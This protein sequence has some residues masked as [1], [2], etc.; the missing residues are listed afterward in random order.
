MFCRSTLRFVGAAVLA[1]A[2][3]WPGT[4]SATAIT[5]L[6]EFVITRSGITSSQLGSYEGQLVW[7]RDSF[8]DGA[9]PPSGG[10]F[11]SGVSGSYGVLGSYP[12]GSESRGLLTLNSAF[13]GPYVNANGGGRVLQRSTLLTD[14][15][16]ETQAGLKKAFHTFSVFGLFDLTI[17]SSRGDGYGISVSDGGPLGATE[18][19]DLFVRREE[20]NNVVIRLQEQDFLNS[21]INTLELD[22]LAAPLG[23]D[24]IELR[25]QRGDLATGLLTASYRFWDNGSAITDFIVMS[26]AADFFTTNG[27]ARGNFFAVQAIPEPG[28]LGIVLLAAGLLAFVRSLR[29]TR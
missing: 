12:T 1:L 14:V 6:D 20:N 16:P 9:P 17:P 29:R 10:T 22:L 2:V 3:A 26:K 7:Y 11:F 28:T 25:L 4:V 19:I 8:S 15:D 13:G 23:A 5:Q 18:A 27:W 24:Q 21:M